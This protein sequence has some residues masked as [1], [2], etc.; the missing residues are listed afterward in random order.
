MKLGV[1]VCVGLYL[2]GRWVTGMILVCP[3]ALWQSKGREKTSPV[4]VQCM[5]L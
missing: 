5:L 3:Y 1:G 2:L 4:Y